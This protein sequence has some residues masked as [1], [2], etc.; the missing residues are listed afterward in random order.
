MFTY[1][2]QCFVDQESG[3][4]MTEEQRKYYNAM[5]QMQS[6]TP[7][8]PIPRP[9]NKFAN[10]VSSLLTICL[11]KF[12]VCF[13]CTGRITIPSTLSWS[14]RKILSSSHL[15]RSWKS[16]VPYVTAYSFK[17]FTKNASISFLKQNLLLLN[18]LS[19]YVLTYTTQFVS[20]SAPD[21]SHVLISGFI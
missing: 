13:T 16:F 11:L 9:N 7:K 21:T 3:V 14:I 17:F 6:K 8:K 18:F 4:L 5:K 20:A 10:S 1:N 19:P 12:Q 15:S 2:D